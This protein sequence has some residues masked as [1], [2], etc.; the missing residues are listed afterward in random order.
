MIK[1]Y[2]FRDIY[3]KLDDDMTFFEHVTNTSIEK[4]I[5]KST[6]VGNIQKIHQSKT[7]PDWEEITQQE[8]EAV[9]SA[10]IAALTT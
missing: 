5:I 9:R 2:K 10:V 4:V 3:F 6:H 8:F 1:Y 7:G